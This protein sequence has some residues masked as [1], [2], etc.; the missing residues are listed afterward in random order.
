MEIMP[1]HLVTAACFLVAPLLALDTTPAHA[2]EPDVTTVDEI[3]VVGSRRQE[4]RTA[5]DSLVPVDLIDGDALR[6]QGPV[7]M[8]ALLAAVIPSYNVDQQAINDA[9]TLIRPARL[10]GLPPDA[11]LAL[12][13]GKRRH[14]AAVIAFLGNGVADGSQGP[15]LSVIP[16]IAVKR[17]ELLRDGAAAQYGSDAIAGVINFVL[18]DDPDG[19]QVETRWGQFYEGDGEG[20]SVAANAGFPLT[21]SGF[22]NFSFEYRESDGTD[23]SQQRAD[24]QQLID[25]G[26]RYIPDPGYRRVFHP[27]VMIWGAPEVQHDFKFFANLGLD[28]GNGREAYAFGN[29]AERE[30]EG[31]FYFRNPH[32]RSGVFQGD[33]VEVGGTVYDTVKVA[34]LSADGRSGNCSPIRIV[35]HVAQASDIAAVEANPDCFSFISAFPGGFTPRFGG[36]VTDFSGAA[37]VRG[38]LGENWFFDVSGVV[39]R[40]DVDFFM[41]HTINPQLLAKLP[42]GRRHDI[43]TDYFPGSYTETD[44]TVNLDLSRPVYLDLFFSPLNVALGLEYREERFKVE[45]GEE[46]SWFIDDRPGGLAEQGFGIG[47]NGFTGFG[48]RLAG[49]FSRDSY[50]AYVDLEVDLV[51]SFTVAAAARYE[52]H[53]GVGDTLDGKFTARWQL[54][55]GMALRGAVSTGFRTPTV[56]QANILNVTTAFTGGVLADEATLPP[57]H[58]AARLVGAQP[59]T[60]EESVNFSAGTVLQL[61]Q[62]GHHGRLLP[63]RT[64]G[65]HRPQQREDPESGERRDPAL[66]GG[67]GR[68]QL[69]VGALLHQRVRH[70]DAGRRH[71]RQLVHGG[72]RRHEHGAPGRELDGH[73]RRASRPRRDQR[74]AGGPDRGKHARQAALAELEPR[75]G[76]VRVPRPGPVVRRVRRVLHGRRDRPARRRCP[77]AGRHRAGLRRQPGD[78]GDDRRRERAG[79]DPDAAVPQRLGSAVRRNFA[80]RRQRRLLLCAGG[81]DSLTPDAR[82][83]RVGRQESAGRHRSVVHQHGAHPADLHLAAQFDPEQVQPVPKHLGQ[84]HSH[85]NR[86]DPR[87]PVDHR[88]NLHSV[89]PDHD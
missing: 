57:T 20:L 86:Q 31:G 56:G 12:V 28:L 65:S 43:P 22:A 76:A 10:R 78:P 89:H 11:T 39:G 21:R 29:Y 3:V 9:A 54:T 70:D 5:A 61:G 32:T 49:E 47:S 41:K 23:R 17:V 19:R 14:R 40:S 35:D 24:A 6:N 87:P 63:D 52:D 68:H 79:R 60:P 48:P 75:A 82:C 53:D 51:R 2:E 84:R 55:D 72:V 25:A 77:D 83:G 88:G 18:R 26:N 62:R 34:D 4:R 42:H 66:A 64:G 16:A 71:R 30:A 67:L 81:L 8:D 1:K 33:P 38:T 44:Y 36:T 13:N 59:L 50:A 73:E 74:Q 7:D 27:N 58:P 69:H 80:L 37:G 46:N 45:S 85:R 15:D